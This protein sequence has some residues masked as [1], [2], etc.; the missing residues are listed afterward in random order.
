MPTLNFSSFHGAVPRCRN[1]TLSEYQGILYLVPEDLKAARRYDPFADTKALLLDVVRTGE[2]VAACDSF[3]DYAI[4]HDML[5]LR[6]AEFWLHG[7]FF[8][9][10]P[11]QARPVLDA[12]MA[13]VERYGLPAWEVRSMAYAD[14]PAR[15]ASRLMSRQHDPNREDTEDTSYLIEYELMKRSCQ[16]KGSLSVCTLAI[17]LL[18]LYLRFLEGTERGD[19]FL[20]NAEWMIHYEHEKTPRLTA[21]VFDLLSCIKLAHALLVSG[22][23]K[24]IRQCKHC[25]KFF[26]AEDL[27][28]EYCS[29]R[30]RGAYNSK[31]TR[32]RVKERKLREE[33]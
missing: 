11:D 9:K 15:Y 12:L 22:E 29:P 21:Q 5:P 19:F 18:D 32:K 14:Y 2:Q 27:R 28:A 1:Y 30:C 26:I 25:G 7:D 24:A 16:S 10:C 20:R 4:A 17:L 13:F 6:D 23:G 31:M 8:V 33:Q 3:F